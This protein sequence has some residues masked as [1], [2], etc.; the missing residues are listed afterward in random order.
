MRL[1]IRVRPGASRQS[2]GGL[3]DG[4]L[5]V[6]VT[7]RAVDGRATEAAVSAVARAFGLR[8]RDVTLVS[9]ARSRTKTLE[10]D[11]DE[12]E[13]VRRCRELQGSD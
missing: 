11:G 1:V 4:A 8:V 6:S 9:G 13:L 7:A 12:A 5:L 3:R 2:V 10:L